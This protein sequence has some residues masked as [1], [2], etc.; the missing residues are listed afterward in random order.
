MWSVQN[1][2]VDFAPWGGG[3]HPPCHGGVVYMCN[4][5]VPIYFPCN[6][7]ATN[8]FSVIHFELNFNAVKDIETKL[9]P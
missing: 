9:I 2:L 5:T 8:E 7:S 3:G 6:H 4:A 1:D